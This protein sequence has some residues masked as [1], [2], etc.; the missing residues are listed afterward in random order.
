MED[1]ALF[2]SIAKG[3]SK[4]QEGLQNGGRYLQ[5]KKM[6]E[7]LQQVWSNYPTDTVARAFVHHAQVATAIYDCEGG[8][9]PRAQRPQ[10][11]DA[12]GVTA[13]LRGQ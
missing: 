3:V 10:F 11:W 13:V 2:P 6:W 9:R 5:Y 7:M 12:Q 4:Q 1:A 8:V